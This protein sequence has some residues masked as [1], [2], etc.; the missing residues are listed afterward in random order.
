MLFRSLL[1][2]RGK[3]GLRKRLQLPGES[4]QTTRAPPHSL[5][6]HHGV[7]QLAQWE[8]TC[9]FKRTASNSNA[10]PGLRPCLPKILTQGEAGPTAS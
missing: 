7:T 3:P 8:R 2:F 10:Q 1:I 9:T 4:T 5:L 6:T